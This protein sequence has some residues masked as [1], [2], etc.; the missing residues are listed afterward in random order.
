MHNRITALKKAAGRITASCLFLLILTLSFGVQAD[1]AQILKKTSDLITG[2]TVENNR[3]V[4][5]LGGTVKYIQH[6]KYLSS[7]FGSPD[8]IGITKATT[9]ITGF[10]Y[11]C[12]GYYTTRIYSDSRG[13][14]LLGYIQ[15]YVSKNDINNSKCDAIT[16]P[17]GTTPP[18][19]G[20]PDPPISVN[21]PAPKPIHPVPEVDVNTTVSSTAPKIPPP[22]KKPPTVNQYC[23]EKWGYSTAEWELMPN[24]EMNSK[25]NC[26]P[27]GGTA[28]YQIFAAD[29]DLLFKLNADR[30]WNFWEAYTETYPYTGPMINNGFTCGEL[31]ADMSIEDTYCPSDETYNSATKKCEFQEVSG[32]PGS[33]PLDPSE[34]DV[35]V[36]D[37]SV[38][39]VYSTGGDGGNGGDTGGGGNEPP[40]EDEKPACYCEKLEDWGYLCCI[41]ECPGWGDYLGYLGSLVGSAS[42]PPVPDLPAP[43]IPNIFDILN[44]VDKRN[45]PKPTGIEDPNLGGSSFDAND[46]MNE[47]PEIEFRED[48]TGGFN[49]V[50]P[51][52]T[53]PEDGSEAPRPQEE[54]EQLPYPGGSGG[55]IQGGDVPKPENSGQSNGKVDYPSEPEGSAKPPTSG[56]TAKPP[57]TGG[58]IKYPGT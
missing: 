46:I 20:Q 8:D 13:Q 16:L 57:T 25:Y 30:G 15:V 58:N 12:P 23:S 19:E 5:K 9:R 18:A 32:D 24:T 29:N 47:S 39:G 26:C 33:W 3:V 35:E 55:H 2:P 10:A 42:A 27:T 48:P 52:E 28:S 14:N 37:E 31:P 43:S 50:N 11:T 54:L 1:A 6:A 7:D 44:D 4:F 41:F 38:F 53:L 36:S 49:I 40:P 17:P 51:L 45:P 56:G 34:Y 22:P 21:P